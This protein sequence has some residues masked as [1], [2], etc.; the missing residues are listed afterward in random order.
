MQTN[1]PDLANQTC[2]SESERR[3][4]LGSRNAFAEYEEQSYHAD[5][6]DQLAVF[7]PLNDS[8]PGRL[9]MRADAMRRRR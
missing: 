2:I 5:L 7:N 8:A 3:Q 6:S 9:P 1:R 4:D